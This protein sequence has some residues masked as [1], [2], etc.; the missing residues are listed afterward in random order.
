MFSLNNT[1]VLSTILVVGAL[2]VICW[3]ASGLLIGP[4][5]SKSANG[6][7]IA[8]R[9][10]QSSSPGG[11]S[12]QASSL[13]S[14]G[15]NDSYAAYGTP[16]DPFRQLLR[17]ASSGQGASGSTSSSAS[18]S[19]SSA[20]QGSSQTSSSAASSSSAGKG[21]GRGAGR[22]PGRNAG[23][24]GRTPGAPSG[25]TGVSGKNQYAGETG[26]SSRNSGMLNSGGN[27]PVPGR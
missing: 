3:I 1:R 18:S 21:A 23:A 12:R 25:G 9:S 8:A 16:K 6:Q 10:P 11:G 26:Q 17:P 24:G 20:G 19:S 27:L 5:Q 13:Q 15:M 2:L 14:A 22:K 4:P 7:E